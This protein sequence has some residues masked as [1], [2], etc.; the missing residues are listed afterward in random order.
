MKSLFLLLLFSVCSVGLSGCK[1][2]PL[3]PAGIYHSDETLHQADVAITSAYTVFDSF[4]AFEYQNHAALTAQPQVTAFA[5]KLRRE[6][7]QW[8]RS[9]IALRDAY[10]HAPASPE[11]KYNLS[12]A[13]AVLRAA[14]TEASGYVAASATKPTP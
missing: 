6:S 8:F 9:A 4:L 14:A 3:D 2:A 1:T 5:Q 7:P 10:A 11:A 13:L 12:V